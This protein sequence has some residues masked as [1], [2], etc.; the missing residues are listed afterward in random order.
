MRGRRRQVSAICPRPVHVPGTA[1]GPEKQSSEAAESLVE[2][3]TGC[4]AG[5][6]EPDRL[7]YRAGNF[8]PGKREGGPGT[9][10]GG[11][12]SE[13]ARS[14]EAWYPDRPGRDS[15]YPQSAKHTTLDD[16][17]AENA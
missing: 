16:V 9:A 15:Q 2:P 14:V 17:A 8:K 7:D 12:T 3:A 4:D 10:S 11:P 5:T 6:R 13:R 1:R